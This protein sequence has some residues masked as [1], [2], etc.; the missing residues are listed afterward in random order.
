MSEPPDVVVAGAGPAGSACAIV[1]RQ[2]GLR[3]TLVDEARPSEFKV[4]ESLP[5]AAVR[6]LRRLGF[7]GVRDVLPEAHRRRCTGNLSSWGRE[8]WIVQDGLRNPEGGGWHC[9]RPRFDEALRRRAVT[10]GVE[11]RR[12]VV[13]NVQRLAARPGEAAHGCG[14]TGGGK[15]AAASTP[16]SRGRFRISVSRNGVTETLLCQGV[17]DA[18]GRR[19]AVSKRLGAVRRILDGQTAAVAWM[20]PRGDDHED[21]TRIKS[22]PDG[23]WYSARLPSGHRVLAF[24]GLPPLVAKRVQQP[25]RLLDACNGAALV[26]WR[27]DASE[28]VCLQAA[29]A[30]V[31]RL[32]R[33]AGSGW[34]AAGDAALGLDPLSSQ[35]MFF[36]LY[37]GVRGAECLVQQTSGRCE[38]GAAAVAG[39]QRAVDD[40]FEAHVAARAYHYRSENRF[41]TQPY[42]RARLGQPNVASPRSV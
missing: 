41:A 26:P 14:D 35:D 23:W 24:F 39:Y 28:L 7:D 38:D 3:V 36:A 12:G 42:W 17:V 31:A 20:R 40:V 16:R 25:E 18:T 9:D 2:A 1:L 11:L 15:S 22:T 34:I 4:G 37:S 13:T 10:L 5:G 30:S 32:E 8:G 19:A 6:L 27:V 29:D 33:C 21:A